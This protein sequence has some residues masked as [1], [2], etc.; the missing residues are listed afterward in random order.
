MLFFAL[1]ISAHADDTILNREQIVN[2]E[3]IILDQLDKLDVG[4]ITEIMDSI[5]RDL[6]D[7]FPKIDYRDYIMKVIRGETTFSFIDIIRGSFSLLFREVMVNWY[8]LIQIILLSLIYAI[9][10]NLQSSFENKT[11]SRLAYNVC[12]LMIASLVIKSFFIAINIGAEAIEMMV[13]FMQLLT[14]IVLTLILAMG[15]ITTAA[16]FHPILLGGI[17]LIGTVVKSVVLPLLIF[18]AVLSV[19]SNLSTKIQISKLANLFKQSAIALL[20]FILTIF[21]GIISIQGIAAASVDGIGLRTTKFAIERFI[22]IVGGFLSDAM[23]TVIG[24]T[25]VLKNGIGALGFLV[26][27][28]I[29]LLPVI[30]ILS[31]VVIYRFCIAVIEPIAEKQLI[32]FLTQM[33]NTL[34]VLF[35]AVVAVAIM[36]FVTI[37]IVVSTGNIT[38]MMR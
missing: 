12:Y 28:L 21:V 26:I 37:T 31:L 8:L 38:L 7:Y 13:T 11:I 32:D 36:F 14:P 30:K 27:F 10:S 4:N 29:C 19:V 6:K 5:N 35:A 18:S 17:G 22:P 23:D 15:G 33:S 3:T 20:G 16:F 34:L 9:L 2:T 1:S 24:C 25:L